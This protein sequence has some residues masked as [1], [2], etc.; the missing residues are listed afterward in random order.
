ML[1]KKVVPDSK[2]FGRDSLLIKAPAQCLITSVASEKKRMSLNNF[3]HI[4]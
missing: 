1:L 2:D 3:Q 4:L